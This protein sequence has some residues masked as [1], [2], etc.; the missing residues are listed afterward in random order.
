MRED[1]TGPLAGMIT[2]K[3]PDL[4]GQVGSTQLRYHLR[5]T[6]DLHTMLTIHADWMPRRRRRRAEA[7][8]RRR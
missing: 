4:V 8:T 2:K 1:Y 6:D 3:R 7:R 5:A